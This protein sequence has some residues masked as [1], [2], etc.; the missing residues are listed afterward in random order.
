MTTQHIL[1]VDDH[2]LNRE[3][4]LHLL[5]GRG[6]DVQTAVDGPSALDII[7]LRKPALILMDLQLPGM[8][9]YEL[10]RHLKSD[11]TTADIV[12]IAVTSFAMAGDRLKA[13]EAGCDDYVAKPINIRTLPDLVASH[14]SLRTVD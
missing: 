13:H 7:A 9:G 10:T 4:M 1:V 12:V 14:L 8:N 3:L 6:Y 2:A 11:P 5:S